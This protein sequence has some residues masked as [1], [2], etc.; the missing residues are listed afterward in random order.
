MKF[1]DFYKPGQCRY[2]FEVFPVKTEEGA[3]NLLAVLADLKKFNPAFVSVTYGAMGTTRD[4]TRDLALRIF[5]EAKIPTA[6]HF[7]CVGS[8]RQEIQNYVAQ[9]K[10]EGLNLVVALRGDPP[11]GAQKFQPPADG[12][13]YAGEL[14][15]FLKKINGFSLAVAGYP[16]KH[17]EA[18]DAKT[19]LENL[20][21]KVDAGADMVL[22]QLFYDNRHYFDFVD[23]ARKI[24]IKIPI[25]PGIMPI[26]SLKQVEKITG[27][28]GATIPKH[29]HAQLVAC[30]DDPEKTQDLGIAHATRQCIELKKA[31]VP[32]IHFYTLN[33]S[34][35]VSRIIEA[36]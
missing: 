32:G 12:F 8:G 17:I 14:V 13:R 18:P 35:S 7:T 28:C 9:L 24:G 22:T 3:L 15:S 25:I 30:Q 1:I 5:H 6:F 10:K 29:L 36:L 34:L 2:S 19:D 20:K 27:L 26:L 33:K 16:E 31:G 4:L 23:R 11:Q 21:R